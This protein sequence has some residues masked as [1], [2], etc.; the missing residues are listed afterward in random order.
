MPGRPTASEHRTAPGERVDPNNSAGPVPSD[1]RMCCGPVDLAFR[2]PAPA[3]VIQGGT[4]PR[5]APIELGAVP[6]KDG[7]LIGIVTAIDWLPTLD[8]H[9]LVGVITPDLFRAATPRTDRRAPPDPHRHPEA[10]TPSTPRNGPVRHGGSDGLELDE[11]AN[12]K[13]AERPCDD[14]SVQQVGFESSERANER[15]SSAPKD[16]PDLDRA[17]AQRDG[18]V[19]K[20]TLRERLRQATA[21]R[22]LKRLIRDAPTTTICNDLLTVA[23]RNERTGP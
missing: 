9:T 2:T 11:A 7:N 17:A 4:P 12:D 14:W 13:V 1:R 22:E 20:V 3:G 6:S 18:R 5:P 15:R 8:G 10:P 23:A 19:G 21:C 16:R